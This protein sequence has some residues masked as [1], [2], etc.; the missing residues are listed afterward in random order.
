MTFDQDK[1]ILLRDQAHKRRLTPE[2]YPAFE[3]AL[4]AEGSRS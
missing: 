1:H 4:I 3:A 2:E